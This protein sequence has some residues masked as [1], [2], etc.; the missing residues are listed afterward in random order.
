MSR[1]VAQERV[2]RERLRAV[3]AADSAHTQRMVELLG[4]EKEL[5]R[6]RALPDRKSKDEAITA[7]VVRTR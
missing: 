2:Y 6:I 5:E 7:A 4:G 1:L 3:R